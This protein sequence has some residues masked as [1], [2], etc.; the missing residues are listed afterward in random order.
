VTSDRKTTAD[1]R[2]PHQK[3]NS[4]RAP[5]FSAGPRTV[6][7]RGEGPRKH[8]G[9]ASAVA[10]VFACFRWSRPRKSLAT[11]PRSPRKSPAE[12]RGTRRVGEQ[13]AAID[14]K[15]RL[16]A[17]VNSTAEEML[18]SRYGSIDEFIEYIAETPPDLEGLVA[19]TAG[20]DGVSR[21]TALDEAM[22]ALDPPMFKKRLRD[23]TKSLPPKERTATRKV[24]RTSLRGTGLAEE[25]L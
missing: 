15:I 10:P 12:A 19:A 7:N 17:H 9:S 13:A 5:R 21:S 8:G 23:L 24:P 4:N 20:G 6:A 16:I 18:R 22:A 25:A 11:G 14:G 3:A 1:P 2:K